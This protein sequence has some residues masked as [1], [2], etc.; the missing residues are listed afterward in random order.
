MREIKRKIEMDDRRNTKNCQRQAKGAKSRVRILN[1][2]YQEKNKENYYNSQR[3]E[4]DKNRKGKTRDHCQNIQELEGNF[5]L[6][7][8]KKCWFFKPDS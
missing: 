5:Y 2:D 3:K 4:V 8:N 1:A 7:W 6:K